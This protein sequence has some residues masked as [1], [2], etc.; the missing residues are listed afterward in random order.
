MHGGQKFYGE[1][2]L[3]TSKL[4]RCYFFLSRSVEADNRVRH[5]SFAYVGKATQVVRKSAFLLCENIFFS[6]EWVSSQDVASVT[7]L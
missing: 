6:V 2:D 3:E 7:T 5:F 1:G 4:P